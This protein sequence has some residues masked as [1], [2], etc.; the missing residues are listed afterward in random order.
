M[1]EKGF[2]IEA[3]KRFRVVCH[4][5]NLQIYKTQNKNREWVFLIKCISANK[6]LLKLFIIFKEK[7]QMKTWYNVLKD[8]DSYIALS[9]NDWINNVL[10]LKWFEKYAQ[11]LFFCIWFWL[12]LTNFSRCFESQTRRILKGKYRLLIFDE[13]A[14]HISNKVIIFYIDNDIILLCL[15]SHF[16]HIL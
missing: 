6:R 5:S 14:F 10:N 7:R 1:N 8:E 2:A 3:I 9:E 11:I 13:H 15:S 4:K 16:T 12:I